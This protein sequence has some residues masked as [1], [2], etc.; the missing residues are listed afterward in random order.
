MYDRVSTPNEY[1]AAAK[2]ATHSLPTLR[3]EAQESAVVVEQYTIRRPHLL[4]WP[5]RHVGHVVLAFLCLLPL[6]SDPL[7]ERP[8]IQELL[9]LGGM[10]QSAVDGWT[11]RVVASQMLL[12]FGLSWTGATHSRGMWLRIAALFVAIGVPLI[13]LA[14]G[15][16]SAWTDALKAAL[17]AGAAPVEPT[18]RE[19]LSSNLG[20]LALS[21]FSMAAHILL[22]HA[23]PAVVDGFVEV[24]QALK[25]QVQKFNARRAARRVADAD[26]EATAFLAKALSTAKKS[27]DM[28]GASGLRKDHLM[29]DKQLVALLDEHGMSNEFAAVAE[30]RNGKG[31]S[32]E[33]AAN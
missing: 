29:V 6:F 24:V 25:W 20:L 11:L 7:I 27:R 16:Q 4:E 30:E 21:S 13:S 28:V 33:R 15:I 18:L 5:I 1:L 2:T 23:A 14:I 9:R 31:T 19:V 8:L 32:S 3:A 12:I 22:W 10:D 17:D 26:H